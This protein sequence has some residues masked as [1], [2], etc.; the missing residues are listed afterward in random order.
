MFITNDVLT[1]LPTC[2]GLNR[3]SSGQYFTNTGKYCPDDGMF[4]P[5]RVGNSVNTSY[6][7]NIV[8]L[9]ELLHFSLIR[10]EIYIYI[11]V[12]VCVCVCVYV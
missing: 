7:I 2:F 11:Y 12:C 6:L 10:K 3:P 4:R 9:L 1:M 5:K 8:H